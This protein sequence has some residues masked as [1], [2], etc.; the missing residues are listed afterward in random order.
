MVDG[1]LREQAAVLVPLRARSE[2]DVRHGWRRLAGPVVA[3]RTDGAVV[4]RLNWE[5]AAAV[6]RRL[7]NEHG[8][9]ADVRAAPGAPVAFPFGLMQQGEKDL[10]R[11]PV[12]LRPDGS[13]VCGG[14][15]PQ[16]ALLHILTGTEQG[17]S[18]AAAQAPSRAEMQARWRNGSG[19]DAWFVARSMN[20]ASPAETESGAEIAPSITGSEEISPAPVGVQSVGQIASVRRR[21]VT[22]LN[23][24]T[25]VGALQRCGSA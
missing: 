2:I 25:V 17:R 12:A 11:Q 7:L 22:W 9:S 24:T 14:A 3:T 16:H 8:A 10:V 20:P 21:T 23:G 19:P 15:V 4:H 1:R 13:I 6:Y 5:P 18:D